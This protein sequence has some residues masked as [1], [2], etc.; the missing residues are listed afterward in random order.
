MRKLFLLL[1]ILSSFCF[2]Q[3][4]KTD[5][6]VLKTDAKY[7]GKVITV[8][9]NSVDFKEISKDSLFEFR[10]SDILY[11]KLTNGREF[12]FED[13]TMQKEEQEENTK[14][15]KTSKTYKGTKQGAQSVVIIGYLGIAA[16]FLIAMSQK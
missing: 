3:Q 9:S 8:K 13:Q 12:R 14:D 2:A 6:L 15:S 4:D 10:K 16:L 5:L 11:I 7:Y 1:I